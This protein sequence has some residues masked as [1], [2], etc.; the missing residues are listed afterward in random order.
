MNAPHHYCAL[1]G[2]NVWATQRLLA[3]VA[4]V[5][6]ADYRRD[7]GLF[8]KSIHGTLN[9][10]LV[11]EHLLWRRRFAEGVSPRVALDA[12]V[13][14]DRQALAQALTDGALA[15]APLIRSW[16][17]DRF[18][19]QLAYTTMR[20]QPAVLP[21]GLTLTHV[22]NHGTLHRG[23]ITAALTALGHPAPELDMV[24][25]LQTAPEVI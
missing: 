18:N 25:W 22:F 21:F 19:G 11:G 5:A 8:F 13:E 7:M 24:Y 3:A 16:A 20:G 23:Q 4:D 6:D 2:Y 10:L 17:A 9:H 12:E 14:P 1:A 15:W